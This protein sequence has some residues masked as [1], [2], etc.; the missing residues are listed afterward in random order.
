V[1]WGVLGGVVLTFLRKKGRGKG[2]V[3]AGHHEEKGGGG[4]KGK[5]TNVLAKVEGSRVKKARTSSIR[6][7]KKIRADHRTGRKGKKKEEGG[8]PH[9]VHG[10]RE[11]G[12]SLTKKKRFHPFNLSNRYKKKRKGSIINV[13]IAKKGLQGDRRVCPFPSGRG[14]ET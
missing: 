5:C 14:K 13:R 8:L 4:K 11:R 10:G 2:G 9:D 7:K 6:E 1:A 3:Y 12:I